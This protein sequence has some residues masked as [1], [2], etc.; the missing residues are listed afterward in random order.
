[1]PRIPTLG[2]VVGRVRQKDLELEPL[3]KTLPQKK[4]KSTLLIYIN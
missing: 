2:R 4:K 1:M 3:S